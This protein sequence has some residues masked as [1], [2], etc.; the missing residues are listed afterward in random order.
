VDDI[1]SLHIPLANV[2]SIMMIFYV[3]GERVFKD[4]SKDM[5]KAN[6]N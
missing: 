1:G 4:I 6:L 5:K 3:I 2:F